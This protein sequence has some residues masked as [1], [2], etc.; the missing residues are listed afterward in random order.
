MNKRRKFS[1]TD[2]L[3]YIVSAELVGAVS[4]LITGSFTNFYLKYEKPPL[5]PLSWLFPVV[6]VILYA[7]MGTAAYLVHSSDAENDEKRKA[8]AVYWIQLA[9]NFSWSI[10]FFRFEALWTAAAVI[11]I[12]LALITVMTIRFYKIR[13][14]AGK[15][16]V[17]YVLWVAFAAYLN[18]ASAV[19][20]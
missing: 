6:W 11:L 1:V 3:I 20:N 16:V 2:L 10:I 19:I 4:A 18:I 15:I 7:A 17:P 12:L 8:L 5:L 9:L 14:I 13:P